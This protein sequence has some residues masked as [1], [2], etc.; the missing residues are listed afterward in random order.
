MKKHIALLAICSAA[1]SQAQILN[2]NSGDLGN[3]MA[4][5][6]NA[7]NI[8]DGLTWV[9]LG[10]GFVENDWVVFTYT[11][12]GTTMNFDVDFESSPKDSVMEVWVNNA[13]VTGNDDD[14]NNALDDM[15]G[16][17]SVATT[18]GQYINTVGDTFDSATSWNLSTGDT[19][20]VFVRSFSSLGA[21]GTYD[22]WVN[23]PGVV[24][25]P[26]TMTVLGLGA[27]AAIARRR[28]K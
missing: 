8:G 18:A 5:A 14:G 6:T 13:F 22:L 9:T 4:L 10:L 17:G 20:H 1:V 21:D 27:L 24:P 12:I 3:T 23:T 26:A 19:V 2:E 16:L 11:G 28:R 7:G 25:E 15:Q